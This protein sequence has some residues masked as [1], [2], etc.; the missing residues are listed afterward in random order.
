MWSLPGVRGRSERIALAASGA[1]LQA[2]CFGE[3]DA[4]LR[5]RTTE[6]R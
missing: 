2:T 3:F 6:A 5:R 4:I 1:G